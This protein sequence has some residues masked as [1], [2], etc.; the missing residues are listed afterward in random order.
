M[1]GVI[2]STWTLPIWILCYLNDFNNILISKTVVSV[3]LYIN[4]VLHYLGKPTMDYCYLNMNMKIYNLNMMNSN[5]ELLRYDY[6]NS[7]LS[8]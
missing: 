2:Y 7:L 6:K 5:N 1:I 8:L 3:K 4:W